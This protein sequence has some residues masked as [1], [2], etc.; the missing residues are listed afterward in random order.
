VA[1]A[2]GIAFGIIRPGW[3]GGQGY[4]PDFPSPHRGEWLGH[5]VPV[6]GTTG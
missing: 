4:F 2:T 1:L 3:G 6:V 5:F